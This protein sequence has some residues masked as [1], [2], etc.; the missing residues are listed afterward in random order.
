MFLYF[1]IMITSAQP[2][3]TPLLPQQQA[4]RKTHYECF[5]V[6]L[7]WS[8]WSLKSVCNI[9]YRMH[10]DY[11]FESR[12]QWSTITRNCV[13]FALTSSTNT[14]GHLGESNFWL[15]LVNLF[16]FQRL[17]SSIISIDSKKTIVELLLPELCIIVWM[18]IGNTFEQNDCH[19]ENEKATKLDTKRQH[20]NFRLLTFHMLAIWT[21]VMI[22]NPGLYNTKQ[23]GT[24]GTE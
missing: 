6:A 23:T 18:I 4:K 13:V 15:P 22:V 12:I 1:C 20:L 9:C 24:S 14:V 2:P 17:N 5:V 3:W 19:F 7:D 16:S 21:V 8:S 11:D 10:Y